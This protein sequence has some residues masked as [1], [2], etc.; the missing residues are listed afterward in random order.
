MAD[1]LIVG[2]FR[3]WERTWIGT[4]SLIANKH[5]KDQE[6][7]LSFCSLRGGLSLDICMFESLS[8]IR[9]SFSPLVLCPILDACGTCKRHQFIEIRCFAL[10]G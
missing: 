6:C 8:A 9:R 1:F 10:V 3:K 5:I 2:L 4:T 7:S